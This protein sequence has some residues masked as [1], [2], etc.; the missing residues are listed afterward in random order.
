VKRPR[1]SLPSWA[2]ITAASILLLGSLLVGLPVTLRMQASMRSEQE[3]FREGIRSQSSS[4]NRVLLAAMHLAAYPS[5]DSRDPVWL[6]GKVELYAGLLS[7]AEI[8][9]FV[10]PAR[11]ARF[12][13]DDPLMLVPRLARAQASYR[14][15]LLAFDASYWQLV[16]ADGA[17][18]RAALLFRLDE[19]FRAFLDVLKDRSH[20]M[21]MLEGTYN[22]QM[23]KDLVLYRRDVRLVIAFQVAAVL[24]AAGIMALQLRTRTRQLKVLSGL[25]PICS[26]CK[27][28]RDDRGYWNQVESYLHA[29]SEVNFSHGLCPECMKELYGKY[30][31]EEGTELEQAEG[32]G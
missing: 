24:L 20:V 28:I 22:S 12:I 1:R 4:L 27:K 15:S 30:L 2:S 11:W 13:T 32:R 19:G 17:A 25:L 29:H 26:S 7:N 16:A 14:A 31:E 9:P 5:G 18:E 23:N 10:E 21:T 8:P 3:F 6:A